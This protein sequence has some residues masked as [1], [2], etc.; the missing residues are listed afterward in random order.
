[1]SSYL[2]TNFKMRIYLLFCEFRFE[3]RV[4]QDHLPVASYL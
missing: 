2:Q 1:M 4:K 3:M